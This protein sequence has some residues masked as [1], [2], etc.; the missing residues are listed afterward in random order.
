MQLMNVTNLLIL[1]VLFVLGS[2]PQHQYSHSSE[3]LELRDYQ[4]VH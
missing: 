2:L 4:E 1:T 3:I